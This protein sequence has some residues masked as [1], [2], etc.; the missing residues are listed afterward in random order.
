[1]SQSELERVIR[2]AGEQ[3]AAQPCLLLLFESETVST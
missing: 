3:E 2:I 1:M